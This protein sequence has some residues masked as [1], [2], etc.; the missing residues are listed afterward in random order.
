MAVTADARR[1]MEALPACAGAKACP[2]P[3]RAATMTS[4]ISIKRQVCEEGFSVMSCG[5]SRVA[6]AAGVALGLRAAI[7]AGGTSSA[8]DDWAR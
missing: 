1:R 8:S 6:G 5:A 7:G 2:A 3:M 4:F